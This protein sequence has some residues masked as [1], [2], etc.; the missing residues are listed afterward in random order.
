MKLSLD[1]DV[2]SKYSTKYYINRWEQIKPYDDAPMPS[3][4]QDFEHS[5]EETKR[6]KRE[7]SSASKLTPLELKKVQDI[8]ISTN[9]SY[10]M[11]KRATSDSDSDSSSDSEEE[12]YDASEGAGKKKIWKKKIYDE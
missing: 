6:V 12:Y 10:P 7:N 3:S 1:S 9:Y 5:E 4:L 8:V 11:S 2:S